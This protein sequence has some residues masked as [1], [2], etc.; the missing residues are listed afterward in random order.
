MGNEP[1]S[2]RGNPTS[3][4]RTPTGDEGRSNFVNDDPES[5]P[6]FRRAE[7]YEGEPYGG[8]DGDGE[9]SP[10]TPPGLR[11]APT[12]PRAARSRRLAPR[13][14]RGGDGADDPCPEARG[15]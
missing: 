4:R 11:E 8:L 14:G 12:P 3:L 1:S 15:P 6:G 9:E 13:G 5:A 2:A 7:P 10:K